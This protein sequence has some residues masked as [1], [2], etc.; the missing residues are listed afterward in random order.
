MLNLYQ[1]KVTQEVTK[2]SQDW[3]FIKKKYSLLVA[4]KEATSVETEQGYFV[5]FPRS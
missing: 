1:T 4:F 2:T 5:Q 3:D